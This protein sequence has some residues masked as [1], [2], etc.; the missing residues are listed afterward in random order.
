MRS[1]LGLEGGRGLQ[2]R[3]AAHSLWAPP[4]RALTFLLLVPLLCGVFG[5]KR[6]C[7]RRASGPRAALAGAG[8][9][10]R[11]PPGPSPGRWPRSCPSW[12][13]ESRRLGRGAGAGCGHAVGTPPPSQEASQRVGG[14]VGAGRRPL[15]ALLRK[16][17]GPTLGSRDPPQQRGLGA[18]GRPSWGPDFWVLLS[19]NPA[20]LEQ[21]PLGPRVCGSLA[22]SSPGPREP[23]GRAC[24]PLCP[25]VACACLS[26]R[27][28]APA[29][30][31][32]LPLT[33]KR[34]PPHLCFCHLRGPPRGLW[35]AAGWSLQT[36]PSVLPWP[37]GPPMQ[38]ASFL[39]PSPPSGPRGVL[40]A[41]AAAGSGLLCDPCPQS[42]RWASRP[43]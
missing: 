3:R 5:R 35:P 36:L 19:S 20:G 8:H 21:S 28:G 43:C 40:A 39:S 1:G 34:L 7:K 9:G 41:L 25:E 17:A 29:S 32:G 27:A 15:G 2:G 14:P 4:A 38:A 26:L 37:A 30:P 31:R 33:Q 13:P 12:G 10:R 22:G 24:C 18:A 11:R 6:T 16:R 42:L 23:S